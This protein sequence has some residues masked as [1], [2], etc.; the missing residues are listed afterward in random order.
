MPKSV[1][2]AGTDVCAS[3]M[4]PCAITCTVPPLKEMGELPL[5]FAAGVAVIV[6]VAVD[7]DCNE[8]GPQLMLELDEFP[9]PHVPELMVAV[10]FEN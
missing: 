3:T 8:I 5:L 2:C 9:A 7:P 4:L 6:K 1:I 10:T